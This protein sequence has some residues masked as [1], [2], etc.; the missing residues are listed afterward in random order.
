MS[1]YDWCITCVCHVVTVVYSC[2]VS[3][4]LIYVHNRGVSVEVTV[5]YNCGVSVEMK[6]V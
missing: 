4:E 3:V 2:R 5:V 1:C 6:I